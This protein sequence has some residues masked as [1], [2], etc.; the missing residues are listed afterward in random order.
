MFLAASSQRRLSD[1]LV[2]AWA[3]GVDAVTSTK[4]LRRLQV[5]AD[6]KVQQVEPGVV[7]VGRRGA[8]SRTI[9]MAK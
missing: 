2:L 1:L 5:L 6:A 3:R 7:A 9:S 4:L 8:T